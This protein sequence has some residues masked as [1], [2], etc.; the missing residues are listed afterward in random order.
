MCVVNPKKRKFADVAKTKYIGIGHILHDHEEVWKVG[1]E[2]PSTDSLVN[3][4]IKW[5]VRYNEKKYNI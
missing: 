1:T 5:K 4:W 3:E 2:L